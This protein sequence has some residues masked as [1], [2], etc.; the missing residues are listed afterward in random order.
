[1]RRGNDGAARRAENDEHEI[2]DKRDGDASRSDL[3]STPETETL[4]ALLLLLLLLKL[5]LLLLK[6]LLLLR[7]CRRNLMLRMMIYLRLHHTLAGI[8]PKANKVLILFRV[9]NRLQGFQCQRGRK[10]SS[11]VICMEEES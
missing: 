8:V 11:K 5:L 2:K 4:H 3:R 9:A 10:L 1:V 7:C 6:L